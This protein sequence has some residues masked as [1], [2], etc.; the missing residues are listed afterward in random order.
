VPRSIKIDN[1]PRIFRITEGEKNVKPY[2]PPPDVPITNLVL[3]IDNAHS[4]FMFGRF[5]K[6]RN[7]VP[8]IYNKKRGEERPIELFKNENIKEE[9][10]LV[11]NIADKIL[12]AE[13]NFSAIRMFSYPLSSYLEQKFGIEGCIISPI[14]NINAFTNL[15]GEEKILSLRIRFGQENIKT[16]EQKFNLPAMNVLSEMDQDNQTSYEVAV[17]K[18]RKRGSTLNR[19]KAIGLFEN[20]LDKKAPISS[21]KVET[22]ETVYDLLKDNLLSYSFPVNKDERKVDTND[23]YNKA[24]RLYNNRIDE[25]KAN[26]AH[27]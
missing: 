16:L 25:I 18:S 21:I 5:F 11:W 8:M 15:K 2:P 26:L 19:E 9:S 20:L 24:L 14:V 12:L 3:V 4:G 27:D 17:I 6:L 13:Y 10:H 1:F 22:Q 7:D 23:F